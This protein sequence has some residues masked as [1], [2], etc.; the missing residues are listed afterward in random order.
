MDAS[1]ARAA[2]VAYLDKMA[3]G[4]HETVRPR[5]LVELRSTV[6]RSAAWLSGELARLVDEGVLED[7]PDRGVSGLAPR[8][9]AEV[10]A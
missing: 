6:G 1:A 2:L 3:A 5:D 8:V 4:G 9:P 10:S 7:M